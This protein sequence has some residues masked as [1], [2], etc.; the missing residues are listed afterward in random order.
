MHELLRPAVFFVSFIFFCSVSFSILF[1]IE[2]VPFSFRPITFLVPDF[3][4]FFFR[5][6][7]VTTFYAF[8]FHFQWITP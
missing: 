1:L 6:P 8:L 2:N 4:S 7:F 5:F 3:F